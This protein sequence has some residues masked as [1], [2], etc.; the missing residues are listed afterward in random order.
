MIRKSVTAVVTTAY[1]LSLTLPAWAE[2]GGLYYKKNFY[3]W[4][5][6][7]DNSNKSAFKTTLSKAK[8]D[9]SAIFVNEAGDLYIEGN[10]YK[11]NFNWD[12]NGKELANASKYPLANAYKDMETSDTFYPGFTDAYA[13]DENT[14]VVELNHKLSSVTRSNFSTAEGLR[15]TDVKLSSSKDSVTLTTEKQE[16]GKSYSLR[17]MGKETYLYFT[18]SG[19]EVP[20][21]DPQTPTNPLKLVLKNP[22]FLT[23]NTTMNI[24]EDVDSGAQL[25]V[26]SSD[27]KT[28]AVKKDGTKVNVTALASGSATISVTAFKASYSPVTVT[29]KVTVAT[30][31]PDVS[32]VELGTVPASASKTLDLGSTTNNVLQ[33]AAYPRDTNKNIIPGK[34][35]VWASS[36]PSVATVTANADT[37]AGTSTSG[38]STS[39]STTN[40]PT[41]T[42]TAVAAGTAVITATVDGKTTTQGIT[43]TVTG[44]TKPA[45]V[46]SITKSDTT[47]GEFTFTTDKVVQLSDLQGKIT[48]TPDSSSSPSPVAVTVSATGTD[49]K[50]WKGTIPGVTSGTTY[51]IGAASPLTITATSKTVK[52]DNT[53]KITANPTPVTV[54]ANGTTDIA[55]TTVK[56]ASPTTTVAGVTYA[57]QSSDTTKATVSISGSKLTVTGVAESATPVNVTVSGSKTG[58]TIT[59]ITIPVT[60]TKAVLKPSTAPKA[61]DIV[62]TNNAAGADTIEIKNVPQNAVVSVYDAASGGNSLGRT[63]QNAAA[64]SVYI[65]VSAG[66]NVS[67]IYVT[68]TESGKDESTR[69]SV[70]V[71]EA[72]GQSKPPK[73]DDITVINNAVS[74]DKVVVDNVPAGA[75][76]KIFDSATSDTPIGTGTNSSSTSPSSVDV[77]INGGFASNVSTIYV[78]LTELNKTDSVRVSK[79]VPGLSAAPQQSDITVNNAPNSEQD[80]VTVKNVPANANVF[81]Y[82]SPTGGTLLGKAGPTSSMGTVT[83]LISYG[84]S[85]VRFDDALTSVFV[86]I[87]EGT[88]PES[89][90]TQQNIPPVSKAPN[91]Y[92]PSVNIVASKNSGTADTVTLTNLTNV[93]VGVRVNVYDSATNGNRIAYGDTTNNSSLTIQ[94]AQGIKTQAVY[95]TFTESNKA[96]SA[97]VPVDVTTTGYVVSRATITSVSN[98]QDRIDV[99]QIKSSSTTYE[100]VL[101]GMLLQVYDAPLGG[102]RIGYYRQSTD[103][104]ASFTVNK[105]L[106]PTVY[107]TLTPSGSTE[108]GLRTA[109]NL[110]G[111]SAAPTTVRVKNIAQPSADTVI[112]ESVPNNATVKVYKNREDNAELNYKKNTSGDTGTITVD[113]MELGSLSNVYVSI[114]EEGKRE[115]PRVSASVPSLAPIVEK[116]I[117]ANVR[118]GTDTVT[119]SNVPP[120]AT[121]RVYDDSTQ[122]AVIGTGTA[123]ISG[124]ATVAI[125]NGFVKSDSSNINK[126]KVTAQDTIRSES[127]ATEVNVPSVPPDPNEITMDMVATTVKV[128]NVPARATVKVYKDAQLTQL[129]GTPVPNN[130]DYSDAVVVG[131]DT[132][133]SASVYVTVTETGGRLESTPA[134]KQTPSTAPSV[135]NIVVTNNANGNDTA[136]VKSVPPNADVK[137]YLTETG[138]TVLASAHNYGTVASDLTIPITNGFDNGINTIYVTITEQGKLESSPRTKKTFATARLTSVKFDE[139]TQIKDNE[140]D[141]DDKIIITFSD[142]ILPSSVNGA[143]SK[144]GSVYG[145]LYELIKSV[146]LFK[147][148]TTDWPSSTA[149]LLESD[150]LATN[151]KLEL[152]ADG[153][154][155]TITPGGTSDGDEP[156]SFSSFTVN[157]GLKDKLGNS[158]LTPYTVTPTST[159]RFSFDGVSPT[160]TVSYAVGSSSY[161]TTPVVKSGTDLIIKTTPSEPLSDKPNITITGAN[162]LSSVPMDVSSSDYSYTYHVGAGDGT[163]TISF[164]GTDKAG[165]PIVSPTTGNIFIVDNTAPTFTAATTQTS[166]SAIISSGSISIK[167]ACASQQYGN[168]LGAYGNSLKVSVSK[169]AENHQADSLTVNMDQASGTLKITLADNDSDSVAISANDAANIVNAINGR[170][171]GFTAT[172]TNGSGNF[173]EATTDPIPFTGGKDSILLTLTET[174]NMDSNSLVTGD[175]TSFIFSSNSTTSTV[176]GAAAW[177]LN[178][179]SILLTLNKSTIQLKGAKIYIDASHLLKDAAGNATTIDVGHPVTIN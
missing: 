122:P 20:P 60:V 140:I 120:G 109:V 175:L 65:T 57:A 132:L 173:T 150:P 55:L 162:Q 53:A 36:N 179:K 66:L 50:S 152:S 30:V 22:V 91:G 125:T 97:R 43:V 131:P 119:V 174:N 95:V 44:Q 134:P 79:S 136:L 158:I 117:V 135:N 123:N 56:I 46:A 143:L 102:T 89:T 160:M 100:Y 67:S 3:S 82:D 138:G 126:I 58:E 114:T 98:G 113:S 31:I 48:A 99:S 28:V 156:K 110:P 155:I 176:E 78:C 107:I 168:T 108:E 151:S 96:E 77:I 163:A 124:V 41:A 64:G 83:V 75:T 116:I 29:S 93:P 23:P 105:I 73:A 17:Y 19:T 32:T 92:S 177:G 6:I 85:V 141:P 10:R 27:P 74:A 45:A 14:V 24:C 171:L 121:V 88:K 144:G 11:T 49:G 21:D 81:V 112:V 63:N 178:N 80:S 153:K 157:S 35:A 8:K 137:I 167:I 118:S 2:P 9:S 38:T 54:A 129:F 62:V 166:A 51:T 170:N 172:L 16:A 61:E 161:S 39:S 47:T 4:D 86:S 164:S 84:S 127:E 25:E 69:T 148:G 154:A 149:T 94:V 101:N 104:T 165:N 37:S 33:V 146:G 34:T 130:K 133:D 139:G 52:W 7:D 59:P 90:R 106:V 145:D 68:I 70:P 87:A 169:P 103:A 72:T 1:L 111:V 40:V 13:T 159:S 42:V 71:P 5:Y 15:I 18:G 115:S 147:S 26:S 128:N 142:E 76:V 12:K